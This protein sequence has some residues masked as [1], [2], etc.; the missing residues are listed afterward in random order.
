VRIVLL[1][2]VVV[3]G[4]T[5]WWS[6][7]VSARNAA[8]LTLT[9]SIKQAQQALDQNDLSEAAHGFQ[10]V[11]QALDI[12]GRTD[13]Q[14]QALRQTAAEITASAALAEKSLSDILHEVLENTAGASDTARATAAFSKYRDQWVLI[15]AQ[16][17]RQGNLSAKSRFEIEF[18][19]L[20]GSEKVRIVGDLGCFERMVMGGSPRRVIFAAQLEDFTH[21]ITSNESGWC[22]RLRPETAFLWSDS[23]NLARL[24]MEVDAETNRVLQEQSNLREVYQ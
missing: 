4:F 13:P 17:T 8:E 14:A 1:G 19:L 16:V 20:L 6:L 9:A 21:G 3:S 24:G 15:D 10:E 2:V 12:L 23:D 7:R 22:V 5:V 11:K 18:P